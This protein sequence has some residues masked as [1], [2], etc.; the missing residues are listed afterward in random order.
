MDNSRKLPY[1]IAVDFDGTLCENKF[2]DIGEPK[3]DVIKMVQEYKEKG[4]KIILWTCRNYE[5][6]DRAV[7]W[8]MRHGLEFDAINKNLPEVQEI[9]GGDTR[10][11][12]ADLYLDDKNVLLEELDP[13]GS[14]DNY[15]RK[16]P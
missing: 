2:P 16:H 8:C 3:Q 11:V 14:R 10:K 4:W 13:H 12:F 7:M 5:F 1:I 15:T 9:F 6:L